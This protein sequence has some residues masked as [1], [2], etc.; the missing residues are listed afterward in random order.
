MQ[1]SKKTLGK[2]VLFQI[3]NNKSHPIINE[4]KNPNMFNTHMNDEYI[5]EPLDNDEGDIIEEVLRCNHNLMS[6]KRCWI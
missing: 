5:G 2:I 1:W 4:I 6:Q 3:T